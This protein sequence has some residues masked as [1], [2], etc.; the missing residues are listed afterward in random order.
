MN[1]PDGTILSPPIMKSHPANSSSTRREQVG[2]HTVLLSVTTFQVNANKLKIMDYAAADAFFKDIIRRE[3]K[4]DELDKR[5]SDGCQER[6]THRTSD[7]LF[8]T[9]GIT[10]RGYRLS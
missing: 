3:N 9:G 2:R 1:D 6:W 7:W 10:L 5:L 4:L 8:E